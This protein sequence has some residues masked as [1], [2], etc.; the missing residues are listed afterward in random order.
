MID[1]VWL[2]LQPELIPEG[3]DV[4]DNRFTRLEHKITEFRETTSGNFKNL[5]VEK[6]ADGVFIYGSLAKYYLG[7]NQRTLLQADIISAFNK[8]SL[9]LELPIHEAKVNRI[10][11]A[12]NIVTKEDINRYAPFLGNSKYLTRLETKNNI[13]YRSK[14]RGFNLYNKVK[15]VKSRRFEVLIE[16]LKRVPVTRVELK[17]LKHNRLAQILGLSKVTVNDIILCYPDLVNVWWQVWDGIT[18]N[19]ALHDF[20][21]NIFKTKGLVDKHIMIKGIEAMGGLTSVVNLIKAARKKR[22]LFANKDQPGY[23][24]SKYTTLMKTPKLTSTSKL[25]DELEL[26]MKIAYFV[27]RAKPAFNLETTAKDAL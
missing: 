20:D 13:E 8:L 14:Y 22:G 2:H 19:K 16:V 27:N 7:T 26:K 10:D 25:I 4:K 15:E 6:S 5:K 18:K 24:I 17:V 3:F 11:I 1:T 23:L 9:D 12:E 21:P